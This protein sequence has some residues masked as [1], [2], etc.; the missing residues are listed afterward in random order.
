MGSFSAGFIHET[1]TITHTLPEVVLV[2]G[3]LSAEFSWFPGY[4]WRY[5]HCAQCNNH[6]GWKYYSSKPNVVPKT[7][8]GL[9]GKSINVQNDTE[10][11]READNE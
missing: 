10:R 8:I 4:T 2:N 3:P 7:F 6:L 9:S 11:E 1:H 5:V